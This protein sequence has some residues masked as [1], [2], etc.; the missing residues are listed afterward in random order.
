MAISTT[1][2]IQ[3]EGETLT[4]FSK[5]TITQTLNAHHEFTILQP[6]PKEFVNQAIEKSQ[7]YIGQSIKIEIKPNNLA[8]E[9]PLLFYGIITNAKLVRENGS[10]GMIQISGF[11]PTIAMQNQPKNKSYSN[12]SLSDIIQ[13]ITNQ[14]P[15]RELK[16]TINLKDNPTLPYTVQYN[17]SDFT[18]LCRLAEKKAE[19]FY[20]N[21]ENLIFGKP[22]SK[23]FTLEYGRSLERFDIEMNAKPLNFEFTGYDPSTAETQKANATEINY[24]TQGYS[25]QIYDSSKKLFPDQSNTLYSNPMQEGNSRTHL[26]DRVTTQL[27]SQT[28][29]LI[30]ATG[31]SD[32]TGLRI[33]DVVSIHESAFTM[34][35]NP[36]DGVQEQNFGSYTITNITHTCDESSYHN[37]FNA[38]PESSLCPP[39]GNV[40]A[41]PIATTQPAT[42]MDNNDPKGLGRIQVQMAWQK[43]NSESTPWIRMTNPHAGGGK[44]MYFIPEIGEEVLIAFEADNAE[45]PFVLGTMYNGNESSGY[46]TEG[47]DQKVIQTRSGCKILINDAIGSIFLEDPSGNTWLMDGKGNI[48]VNA[49]NDFTVNAGKNISFTAGMNIN[50][51][52]TLNISENAGVDKSTSIGMMHNLFVGGNSIVNV[53]GNVMEN[54]NGDKEINTE[55]EMTFNSQ[56]GMQYSS[57]GEIQKHSQKEVKL[58]SAEKSKL[59]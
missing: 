8:T 46:N 51:S 11:S 54:I 29:N 16:P 47:N 22:Q 17:E 27:Q 31:V 41:V 42:V 23:T 7:S 56:K 3:I 36:Q 20:Y 4:R 39:Y 21:G 10:A 55:K 34:T 59:F 50:S 40:L 19:W 28:A 18:F 26:V 48:N 9:S 35:G 45:K 44:G 57:D 25:K 52:A 15:Q 53:S 12:K 49:P 5:L 58:N 38:I 24:Q 13:E 6:L 33:G 43:N 32:E 37:A 30:I 1:T 2:S 14:F